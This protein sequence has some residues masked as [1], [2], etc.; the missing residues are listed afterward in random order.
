MTFKDGESSFALKHDESK[1]AAGL[2]AGTTYTVTEAEANE[3]GYVT[4]KTEDTGKIAKDQTVTA[5][6]TNTKNAT[7]PE[8]EKGNL[9]VS[10]VVAGNAGETDKEFHFTVKLSDDEISGDYGDMTFADGAAAFT[11]KNGESKTATGLPADIT[12]EVTEAEANQDGYVTAKT[13]NTGKITKDQTV[14]AAFVNTK[15]VTPPEPEN[16]NLTVSKAV[17]GNAGDMDK[18]FHFTI[19]LSNAEISGD[20][21]DMT[22]KD[23]VAAFLLKNGESKTAIDL[24]A[25]ITYEVTEAEA[26]QDGYVTTKTGDTGT[27]KKNETVIAAFINTKN[28]IPVKPDPNPNYTS[29]TVKKE[30][31]LDNGGVRTSS[32]KVELLKNGEPYKS[33]TLSDSNAWE[34]TWNN[35]DDSYDWTVREV[36]VPDGF[37]AKAT[38]NGTAWIIT[39]D[40]KTVDSIEPA[41]PAPKK[42]TNSTPKTGDETQLTLW[43]VLMGISLVGVVAI[44]AEFRFRHREKRKR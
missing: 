38:H 9:T 23:G 44:L 18:E 25:G 43:L 32:V 34:Y 24:P 27:I 26:D 33:V 5:A 13:G 42:P 4:V 36:D 16:G 37:N 39:N 8:P 11:L 1:T 19:K 2:P 20:Y 10:K 6:F 3:D 17:A 40:D 15:N 28:E 21:G 41:D 14:T 12:Y 22:F 30:W 31:V 29:L 35:L 7:P